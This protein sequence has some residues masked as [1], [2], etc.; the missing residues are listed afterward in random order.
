MRQVI[1]A[2]KVKSRSAD[3]RTTQPR[4]KPSSGVTLPLLPPNRRLRRFSFASSDE[5]SPTHSPN[6]ADT[7]LSRFLGSGRMTGNSDVTG[8]GKDCEF[9]G[10]LVG[11]VGIEPTTLAPFPRF[12]DRLDSNKKLKK[13]KCFIWC[14]IEAREPLFL[15]LSCTEFV[16]NSQ[17]TQ[18]C[19]GSHLL[20][21]LFL[22]CRPSLLCS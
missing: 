8:L 10:M 9:C 22:L 1:E 6:S 15:S 7:R 17:S 13:S 11:A 5:K 12:T 20:P 3:R 21:V 16:P 14:R 4:D 19:I 18:C 2:H